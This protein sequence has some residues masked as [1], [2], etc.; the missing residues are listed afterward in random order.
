M[1]KIFTHIT[2]KKLKIV[3]NF[4]IQQQIL[5][6]FYSSIKNLNNG[7][8]VGF[9]CKYYPTYA[10]FF[11]LKFLYRFFLTRLTKKCGA[12]SIDLVTLLNERYVGTGLSHSIPLVERLVK[13]YK[14]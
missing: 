5:F 1:A 2:I 12:S 4:H 7:I 13:E 14:E 11:C 8:D 9:R 3:N 6:F 10:K